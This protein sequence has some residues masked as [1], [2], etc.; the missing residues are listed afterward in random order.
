MFRLKISKSPTSLTKQRFVLFSKT[1]NKIKNRTG[2]SCIAMRRHSLNSGMVDREESLRCERTFV[3]GISCGISSF[4]Q[5]PLK[6]NVKDVQVPRRLNRLHGANESSISVLE[7]TLRNEFLR[8]SSYRSRKRVQALRSRPTGPEYVHESRKTDKS[9]QR[10]P[11]I[12]EP[13]FV[14][15]KFT[16]GSKE[17]VALVTRGESLK[18][19]GTQE[20]K[21]SGSDEGSG[22]CS[23]P[24]STVLDT[25]SE[26][27]TNLCTVRNWK[28]S[29][30]TLRVSDLIQQYNRDGSFPEKRISESINVN[31]FEFQRV[32]SFFEDHKDDEQ[33]ILGPARRKVKNDNDIARARS[34]PERKVNEEKNIDIMERNYS[35][36]TRHPECIFS[37]EN[38]ATFDTKGSTDDGDATGQKNAADC[39]GYRNEMFSNDESYECPSFI[40]MFTPS[41]TSTQTLSSG[42]GARYARQGARFMAVD[43]DIEESCVSYVD[44]SHRREAFTT[45]NRVQRTECYGSVQVPTEITSQKAIQGRRAR[46]KFRP[47]DVSQ[48]EVGEKCGRKAGNTNQNI[49]LAPLEIPRAKSFA[50]ERNSNR[51]SFVRR[52]RSLLSIGRSNPMNEQGRLRRKPRLAVLR[53]LI[54]MTHRK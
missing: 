24:P 1:S 35:E 20:Y 51:K 52:R 13:K 15:D 25:E 9:K 37:G 38:D 33:C 27:N 43:E 21:G 10:Q 30:Y 50:V 5:R 32:R 29:E 8:M 49:K 14:I 18:T 48:C 34:N 26:S 7:P 28:D 45:G 6:L 31:S 39:R 2:K 11:Q 12:H 19:N 42:D 16:K 17:T 54:P 22:E 40:S 47:I 23:S 41:Q 36:L 46:V 53:G 4:L 44:W 3:Q